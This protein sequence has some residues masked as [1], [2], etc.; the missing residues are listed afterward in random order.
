MRA[1]QKPNVTKLNNQYTQ[2][3]TL[4]AHRAQKMKR[5]LRKRMIAIMAVGFSLVGL[6]LVQLYNNKNRATELAQ[7]QNEAS[8]ELSQV[9]TTQ[10]DLEY[11]VQLLEDKDYVAKLAR[12][13][14]YLSEENELIF[15]F[16]QDTTPSFSYEQGVE[17]VD[18]SE[19]NENK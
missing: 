15:S 14:Y 12:N 18:D 4:Q 1:E 16:P 19:E 2:E 13:E 17:E 3:K 10:E 7:M 9:L 5:H 11:Y 6:L 8:Q